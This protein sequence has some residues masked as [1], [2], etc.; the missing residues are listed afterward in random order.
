MAMAAD[1][2]EVL[3]FANRINPNLPCA[4]FFLFANALAIF[5]ILAFGREATI[6][7]MILT[8]EPMTTLALATGLRNLAAKTR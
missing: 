3:E 4:T 8:G 5:F 6:V 7:G 1:K 2:N